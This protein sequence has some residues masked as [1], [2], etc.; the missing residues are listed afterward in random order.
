MPKYETRFIEFCEALPNGM[1]NLYLL[2]SGLL[3]TSVVGSPSMFTALSGTNCAHV[4]VVLDKDRWCKTFQLK[5]GEL[6]VAESLLTFLVVSVW[7]I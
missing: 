3:S 4:P 5:M 7:P 6:L 1:C 2:P